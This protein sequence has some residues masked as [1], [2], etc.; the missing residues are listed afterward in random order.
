MLVRVTFPFLH[1]HDPD[2]Y[3]DGDDSDDPQGHYDVDSVAAF[4]LGEG[5]TRGH[6]W[7]TDNSVIGTLINHIVT[8]NWEK[9]HDNSHFV[10]FIASANV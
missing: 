4:L 9:Q 5:I 6:V 10:Y 3:N 1:G 2:Q 8:V 7:N